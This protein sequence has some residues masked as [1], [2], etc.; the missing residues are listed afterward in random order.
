MKNRI[1]KF[2]IQNITS[3]QYTTVGNEKAVRIE[4]N[5]SE[6]F[7]YSNLVLY[8]VMHDKEPYIIHYRGTPEIYEKFLPDFEQMVK[9]LRFS[10][11]PISEPENLSENENKTIAITNFSGANLTEFNINGTSGSNYPAELYD[12]CVNVAG[13]SFCDFLFKR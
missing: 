1:D 9:S 2:S 10:G 5:E 4:G 12:E 11:D 3:Q 8:L 6:Q 13:K 7:G